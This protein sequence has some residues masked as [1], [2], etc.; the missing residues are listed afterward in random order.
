MAA[1]AK[2]EFRLSAVQRLALV[3]AAASWLSEPNDG[4]QL[5]Y[6][7]LGSV[8]PTE[9]TTEQVYLALITSSGESK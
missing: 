1:L 3:D 6:A 2:R 5:E 7:L 4:D 9:V 8:H